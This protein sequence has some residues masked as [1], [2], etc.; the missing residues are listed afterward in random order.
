MPSTN[1]KAA[2]FEAERLRLLRA[3]VGGGVAL[4]GTLASTA[5]IAA[6]ALHV[7]RCSIWLFIEERQA[8]RCYDCFEQE[9]DAHSEGTVLRAADFPAYFRALESDY[10]V[11]AED[12]RREA[13]TREM[14][15]VYLEPLG[16]TSMLD[17]PLLR[18]GQVVGVVCHEHVGPTRGWSLDERDF[19]RSVADDVAM[20]METAEHMDA[21]A[22]LHDRETRLA[23]LHAW[24]EVGRMTR[25]V[26][27][28]IRNTMSSIVDFATLIE[29][30]PDV[31][32]KRA[33]DA[34]GIRAMAEHG[35]AIA[36]ELTA[37]SPDTPRK[38][39]VVDIGE[40]VHRGLAALR[41]AVHG[42]GCELHL[43]HVERGSLVFADPAELRRML[44]GLIHNARDAMPRGGAICIEVEQI[45]VGE[46]SASFVVLSVIDSGEG[47]RDETL[48][49]IF[50]PFF[51][52]KPGERVGLGLAVIR[53]S[54]ERLGGFIRVETEPGQGT[55][56]Y[57]YLPV[58]AGAI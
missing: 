4:R 48:A 19:A 43:G 20:K 34:S 53:A 49:R 55:T 5:E 12:A 16:I 21:V 35:A 30:D 31:P 7:A 13:A 37:M 2:S 6:V 25:G 8:I 47:M 26:A 18:C 23:E 3:E 15:D 56:I 36:R 10:V 28:D 33:E 54:I 17:A 58:V 52:T 39:R 14:V 27:Q 57:L 51:T 29:H 40:L 24:Q 1:G 32:V 42:T 9:R 41:Y 11:P 50:Q 44:L 38:P 45:D 46:P 22:A